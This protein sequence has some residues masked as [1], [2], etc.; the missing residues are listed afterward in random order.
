MAEDQPPPAK[1]EEKKKKKKKKKG[2]GGGPTR[3]ATLRDLAR[4]QRVLLGG[5]YKGRRREEDTI[6]RKHGFP[7]I[8]EAERQARLAAIQRRG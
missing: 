3:R 8:A 1:E 6:R 7:T 4:A 5:D 2:S